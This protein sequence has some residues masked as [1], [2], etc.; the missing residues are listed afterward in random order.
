VR[1][2]W[3]KGLGDDRN[4]VGKVYDT[5]NLAPRI[6]FAWNVSG[7]RKTVLKAHYGQYYEA[8]F[9]TL[10]SRAIPGRQD[11]VGYCF[12]GESQEPGIPPGYSECER[13]PL[14]AI[15]RVDPDIKHPRVDEFTVGFERA[16]SNDFRLAVTGIWREN[17]NIVDAVLPD[18]RFERVAFVPS[19]AN[20]VTGDPDTG[21]A[22]P[23]DT[24]RWLNRTDSESNGFITNVDGWQYLGPDGN[25]VATAKAYRKY[26]GAMFV[27]S[28]RLKDRWQA[29]VSYVLSK[30]EATADN[31]GF[32]VVPASATSGRRRS[33][34][35]PTP[36]AWPATTGATRSRCS[37][38]TRSRGS[39]SA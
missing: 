14:S 12:D 37:P 11:Y 18:A 20:P 39:K 21:T 10:Y 23:V 29:Q 3:I 32:G 22:Q 9:F 36:T 8:A 5:K 33:P 35:S 28:K 1:F 7:D 2:D 24:F 26:K 16:L 25:P 31:R 30:T 19:R 27:L 17:K 4:S 13:V 15:Y 6:G 34:G 38:P